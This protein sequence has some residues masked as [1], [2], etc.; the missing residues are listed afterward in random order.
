MTHGRRLYAPLAAT[1]LVALAVLAAGC[2]HDRAAPATTAPGADWPMFGITA[3]RPDATARATGVTAADLP[4][5]RKA[6]VRLPGTVDS[7]AIVLRGVRVAGATRDVAFATTTYGLTVAVDLATAKVL[8]TFTPPGY[9]RFARLQVT[10]ASPAADASRRFVYTASPDGKVH[11]LAVADGREVAGG[12]WPVTVTLNPTHE[13]LTSSFLVLHGDVYVTTGGYNGDEPPYQGK[14][15][16]IDGASGRIAAVF[17]SLCS[18]RREII[19]PAT[20]PSSDSAIWGRAGAVLDPASGDLLVASSNGPFD[21][22]GDWSDSVLRLD[23]KTLR[24]NRNWTPT[25]ADTDEK[26]DLDLGSSSPVV[27]GDGLV[28]QSGKDARIHVLDARTLNGHTGPAS[29][30]LGGELQ[31]LPTPGRQMTFTAP[32]VWHHGGRTIV[33]F[34]TQGGT[35]AYV[36]EQRRLATLWSHPDAGTSPVVAGGLLYVYD[37][38]GKGLRVE[39]PA[40]GRRLAVLPA[41]TGH[42]NAPVITGGHVV[43]PEGSVNFHERSGVLDIW[44]AAG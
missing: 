41:G 38:T 9:A 37:P 10:N 32:A 13:K 16:R 26:Q 31:D 4:H 35:T 30:R 39:D 3:T 22:R 23:P 40:T 19:D 20:C 12:R 5:L 8:W 15:V 44:T 33:F 21:G 24:L 36:I 27:L 28:L 29:P 1:C 18:E 42:W 2:G 14:V 17:N 43:L 25:D 7:S 34:A 11:K 6:V